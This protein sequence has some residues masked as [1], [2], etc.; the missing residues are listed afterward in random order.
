MLCLIGDLKNSDAFC[1]SIGKVLKFTYIR[2]LQTLPVFDF[3]GLYQASCSIKQPGLNFSKKS[4]LND[5]VL[6]YLCKYLLTVSTGLDHEH[7]FYEI[8]KSENFVFKTEIDFI[9]TFGTLQ[10]S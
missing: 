7:Y 6:V 4:L 1:F 2:K 9:G 5:Q 3:I 8:Y 10:N